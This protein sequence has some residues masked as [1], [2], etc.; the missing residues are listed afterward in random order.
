MARFMRA[1]A[2]HDLWQGLEIQPV[3][4]YMLPP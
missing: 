3:K 4:S 2:F 1:I